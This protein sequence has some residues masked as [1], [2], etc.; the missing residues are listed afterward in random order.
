MRDSKLRTLSLIG[1]VL[2]FSV[3][4]GQETI[5]QTHFAR[6]TLEN[7]S[8]VELGYA[9]PTG[10]GDFSP[11]GMLMAVSGDGLY[12]LA[13][14][15]RRFAVSGTKG[16]ILEFSPDGHFLAIYD[17][18][19]YEISSGEMVLDFSGKSPFFSPDGTLLAVSEDGLY[20]IQTR[21]KVLQIAEQ[22]GPYP[23]PIFSPDG[24]LLAA[25][26][27][28]VYDIVNMRKLYATD[29]F[30]LSFSQDSKWLIT[31][32]GIY[33]ARTGELKIPVCKYCG[34]AISMSGSLLAI[35]GDGV[36]ELPSFVKRFDIG[37]ADKY[38]DTPEFSPDETIVISDAAYDVGTGERLASVTVPGVFSQDGSFFAAEWD[39]LYD[40]TTWDAIV[41]L[42]RYAYFALSDSVVVVGWDGI[43]ATST[44]SRFNSVAQG[45]VRFNSSDN[46]ITVIDDW[47]PARKFQIPTKYCLIY[48]LPNSDWPFRS[49]LAHVGERTNLRES[50]NLNSAIVT[51]TSDTDLPIFATTAARDWYRVDDNSWVAARVVQTISLPDDVPIEED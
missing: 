23:N 14:G 3:S 11:D 19:L 48:G 35:A 33:D 16:T 36:Y 24:T 37:N 46:L 31:N 17:D 18:G 15:Q 39:N 9:L 4:F 22:Y 50:P 2:W 27:D 29:G 6:I 7:L 12:D 40:T 5:G 45:Y 10:C 43:Y 13:T 51:T 44:G 21:E 26:R 20:D 8:E 49:G 38:L 25:T 1:I 32:K 41:E 42:E 34:A 47:I 30:E 28:H